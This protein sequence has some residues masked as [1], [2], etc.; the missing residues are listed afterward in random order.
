MISVRR[1]ALAV[2]TAAALL[3][4]PAAASAHRQWLLPSSTVLSG[5]DPWITVDAAVSNE[6]FYFDH[7]PMRLDAITVTAP[8]GAKGEIK[9]ATTGKF[10][11]SFDV[12]LDKP[13]TYKIGTAS[14][15]LT[16]S[17]KL[18]GETKRW[19]GTAAELA[20]AIPKEATEVKLTQSAR[21]VEVF[22]TRG[23][24]TKEV[25]KVTGQGLELEPV[26]HPNDL[27]ASEPA[28]F[29][30]MLDGKPAAGVQVDVVPS[31]NRYRAATGEMKLVTDAQGVVTIKWPGAG[32]YWMEAT[33]RGGKA[34]VPAER[35]A[36]YIA[37]LEVLPD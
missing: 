9:N 10:R 18:N 14:D 26:T 6:I 33:V 11:S 25:L 30:L 36:S 8:D 4:V 27:V 35:S 13:G 3:A 29:K 17:Y 1:G 37:T 21:R 22:A 34:S 15:G 2:L 32:M 7:N 24:P 12:Q 20:T 16:A 31:G 28:V 19:R 23:S 5:N